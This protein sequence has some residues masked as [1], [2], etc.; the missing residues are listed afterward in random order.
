M[1]TYS[2]AS[3][4]I[5]LPALA[6]EAKPLDAYFNPQFKAYMIIVVENTGTAQQISEILK[7]MQGFEDIK[8]LIISVSGFC[9]TSG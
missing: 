2:R 1:E 3:S 9:N 7:T 6:I 8:V 4:S 5:L